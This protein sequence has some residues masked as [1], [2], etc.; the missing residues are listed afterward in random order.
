MTCLKIILFENIFHQ[1]SPSFKRSLSKRPEHSTGIVKITTKCLAKWL[2]VVFFLPSC[3]V[4]SLLWGMNNRDGPDPLIYDADLYH[5][6]FGL[7]GAD[8]SPGEMSAEARN[9]E[10]RLCL[11][12]KTLQI[13]KSCSYW[14]YRLSLVQW[15]KALANLLL[16]KS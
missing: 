11:Q 12:D 13:F 3:N 8:V 5:Q 10:R 16:T 2:A 14:L 15:T 1:T 6:C 4:S 9:E 7:W